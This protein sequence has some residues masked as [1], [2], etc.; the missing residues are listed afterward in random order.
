M[1]GHELRSAFLQYFKDRGHAVV[2]SSS[3]LPDDPSVLL[4]TAGMQQ[5][6][7][8]YTGEADSNRDFGTHSAASAQK[9]FRTS[10]IENIGDDTHHTFFEM[11]G[12]FS[13]DG[14]FKEESISF[15]Y[16]FITKILGLPISYVTIFEGS[17]TV[18]KDTESRDIW[19][20]LGVSDVREEGMDDVFWGPTGSGGP[21]GPTTEIYCRNA[22]G[23]DVEVWNV[24]FNE[25]LYNGS[26]E[27]LNANAAGK[28]L[29]PMPVKGI[30]TG[31]GLERLAMIMEGTRSTFETSLMAPFVALVPPEVPEKVKRIFADHLRAAAFLIADGVRPSN[32]GAGYILRRLLR[33]VESYASLHNVA[34][35]ILDAIIH[36]VVHEYGEHYTELREHGDA[37]RTVVTDERVKFG[38]TLARGLKELERRSSTGTLSTEDAFTLYETFGIPYDIIKDFGG[39]AAKALTEE[40]FDKAFARHQ[41]KSRA[42][43]EKKFG[44]HGL[45]LDTGELKASTEEELEKVIRLHT[46][47]HLLQAALRKV[48]GNEVE[49]RGSD[50]TAERTRFDFSFGRKLTPEELAEVER[51]VNDAI[52]HDYAMTKKELPIAEAKQS[53]ALYFFKA[54]YPDTVNVYTVGEQP[55]GTFFSREFCGGPHVAHTGEIKGIKILKEEAS[56]AG[57]RRIRATL[58][59]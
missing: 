2:P 48:L 37:I 6:K 33:R 39:D 51:L 54:K 23:E 20:R 40:D 42:G 8:Y 30:D 44:G 26:R 43:L 41:E 14:Y 5:F 38:Q 57:V 27:E 15:A 34:P 55:D 3:L 21:C 7:P 17:A 59:E 56:S 50:I 19:H 32:K 4:T 12:N 31:M 1:T 28:A 52:A 9:C 16:E 46:A 25:Y 53:G 10:D 47:T 11:L 49:Q 13:F 58:R 24:V 45:I 36:E 22:K 18:P 35:H 29:T